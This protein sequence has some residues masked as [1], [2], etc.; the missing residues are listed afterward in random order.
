MTVIRKNPRPK[1]WS[2]L[3]DVRKKPDEYE[4]V[5]GKNLYHFRRQ[6]SPFE[7]DPHTP[8][9][10]WYL[11]Y[12]EGS[13]FQVTDWEGFRDPHR[14]TYRRYVQLQH[15]HEIY[16]ENLVDQFERHDADAH[17]NSDWVKVLEK[18]YIPSRFPL[19]VLQMSSL[20][21]AQMAPSAYISNVA[22]LQAADELRR[23]QWVAYRAKSLALSYY[24]E[25]ASSASTRQ[26]WE[27]EPLWQPLREAA[28]KLL[29]AYDWGEAFAALDLV[30]KPIFDAVYTNEFAQL[31]HANGDELTALMLENFAL[32]SKRNREWSAALAQYAIAGHAP[33]KELLLQWV[34]KWKP[35]ALHA[36][37]GLLEV[38]TLA[39]TPQTQEE[40]LKRVEKTFLEFLGSWSL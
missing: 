17:L 7:L 35:L 5:T 14:L 25:L 30:I 20:Y 26:I 10:E 6:P 12:R 13:P 15:E 8:I 11:K 29:L 19:H 34:E 31:A 28:E 4:I 40:A 38:L 23:I 1:T 37:Q 32:D 9:N 36:A 27:E 24:P 2:I 33:N 39:P 3:G 16:I 22:F 18:F 21:L